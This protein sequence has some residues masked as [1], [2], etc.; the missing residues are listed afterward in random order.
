[1]K[2]SYFIVLIIMLIIFPQD[3]ISI[4]DVQSTNPRPINIPSPRFDLPLVNFLENNLLKLI[5]GMENAGFSD[6]DVLFSE[7]SSQEKFTRI[8]PLINQNHTFNYSLNAFKA[9]LNSFLTSDFNNSLLNVSFLHDLQ[10]ELE[11]VSSLHFTYNKIVNTTKIVEN[12]PHFIVI[13][14]DPDLSIINTISSI[15]NN[16][17]ITIQPFTGDEIFTIVQLTKTTENFFGTLTEQALLAYDD[18]SNTTHIRNFI[19]LLNNNSDISRQIRKIIQLDNDIIQFLRSI[20][21]SK[22]VQFT[23]TDS[24]PRTSTRFGF[25]I[26]QLQIQNLDLLE[27]AEG[28]LRIENLKFI[29]VEHQSMGFTIFD[30]IND[31]KYMDMEIVSSSPDQSGSNNNVLTPIQSNEALYRVDFLNTGSFQYAPVTFSGSELQ[32][33]LSISD[34]KVNLNPVFSERDSTLFSD[35]YRIGNEQLIDSATFSFHFFPNRESNKAVI[36]FDFELGDW[37]NQQELVN[38]S[39]NHMFV[40]T[41]RNFETNNRTFRLNHDEQEIK[42]NSKAIHTNILQFGSENELIADI[43]L[44]SIPYLWNHTT[45]IDA[46]GQTLPLVYGQKML[47]SLT[48]EAEIFNALKNQASQTTYLYSISYPI[49]SG[50]KITHDPIYSMIS[51][52]P[53]EIISQI[54]SPILSNYRLLIITTSLSII[55]VVIY[56]LYRRRIGF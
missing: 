25:S 36:K 49:F 43:N 2:Q 42:T 30:D 12:N 9:R 56:F 34:L 29:Y 3:I 26:S 48:S 51:G 4:K 20:G 53:D 18:G 37:H 55:A 17:R 16:G 11:N 28:K 5:L 39:L 44:D 24:Q 32:F 19:S 14:F 50:K 6:N 41:I 21:G 31:N 13:L 52:I 35:V 38:L 27:S 45:T 54:I 22:N 40:T 46:F 7:F 8:L 23:T 1:M 10:D 47:G 15:Q 33:G